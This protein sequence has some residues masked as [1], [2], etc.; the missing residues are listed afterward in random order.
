MICVLFRGLEWLFGIEPAEDDSDNNRIKWEARQ[1]RLNKLRTDKQ[2]IPLSPD[3]T[4]EPERGRL[5][6]I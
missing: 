2:P 4:V 1:R 5:Q 6:V 3:K